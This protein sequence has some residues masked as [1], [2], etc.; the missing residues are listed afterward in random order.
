MRE[1]ALMFALGAIFALV[2]VVNP[3]LQMQIDALEESVMGLS[4]E[5]VKL[6]DRLAH[7]L[8]NQ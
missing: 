7:E 2:V 8:H 1:F 3:H 6:E 5:I 4:E